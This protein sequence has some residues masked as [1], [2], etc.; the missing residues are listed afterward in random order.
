MA[1]DKGNPVT[2][3]SSQ[4][5]AAAGSVS[6]SWI[7]LL[8]A[9]AATTYVRVTNGATGPDEMPVVTIEV[10][11]DGSGTRARNIFRA[12][13]GTDNDLETDLSHDHVI[14]SRYIR[15]TIE[16][17]GDQAVT[18]EAHAHLLENLG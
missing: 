1:V 15:V 4:S 11:D 13:T 14:T 5:V 12:N 7:N 10:A 17:P 16:N 9:Q 8:E 3:L 6:S 2:I 18:V